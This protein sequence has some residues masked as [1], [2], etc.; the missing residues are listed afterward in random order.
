L[1]E[2]SASVDCSAPP[3]TFDGATGGKTMSDRG[4][5][6]YISGG[7][8]ALIIIVLLLVLIF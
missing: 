8:L 4:S 3:T 7:V 5:G 6:I 1:P 2:A